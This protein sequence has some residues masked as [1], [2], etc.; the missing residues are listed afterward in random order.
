[1]GIPRQGWCRGKR[2]K[3]I[4]VVYTS[5]KVDLWFYLLMKGNRSTT[6]R[7]AT[8]KPNDELEAR[9][10]RPPRCTVLTLRGSLAQLNDQETWS[11]IERLAAYIYT[12]SAEMNVLVYTV[13][14]YT[15]L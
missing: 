14:T 13:T 5:I 11:G 6:V 3:A 7:A 2:R 10:D 12:E 8:S 15:N 9:K 1:M 4:K